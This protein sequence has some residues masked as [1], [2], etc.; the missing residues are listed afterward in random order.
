MPNVHELATLINN[1]TEQDRT[2]LVATHM[3]THMHMLTTTHTDTRMPLLMQE[4][5]DTQIGRG[6]LEKKLD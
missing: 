5:F 3:H 2:A 6:K 1:R 4:H